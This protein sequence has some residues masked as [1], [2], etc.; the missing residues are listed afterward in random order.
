MTQTL[1]GLLV[2]TSLISLATVAISQGGVTNS[3]KN[4]QQVAALHWY[5]ANQTTT[6]SVGSFPFGMAWDGANFWVVSLSGNTV[7]K[8]RANDGAMLGTFATGSSPDG[9]AYDGTD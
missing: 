6:V 8:V 9:I 5:A 7:S 3:M 4:A 2:F 1:R